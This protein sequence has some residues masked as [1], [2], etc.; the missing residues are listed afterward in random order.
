LKSQKIPFSENLKWGSLGYKIKK[1][2]SV[3][4]ERI[5]EQERNN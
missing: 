4:K 3:R 1:L 5:K 2:K